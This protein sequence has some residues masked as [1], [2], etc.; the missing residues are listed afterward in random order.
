MPSAK[1]RPSRLS[2]N[3]LITK[4]KAL[5]M[6]CGTSTAHNSYTQI[7]LIYII[8]SSK[9]YTS[10][11][12]H[13]FLQSFRKLHQIIMVDCP[14]FE[15]WMCL[16]VCFFFAWLLVQIPCEHLVVWLAIKHDFLQQRIWHMAGLQYRSCLG[17][18]NY[19]RTFLNTWSYATIS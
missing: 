5:K 9:S 11:G 10:W 12:C 3:V 7:L 2:L 14:V 15:I 13:H 4:Q 6:F 18:N 8:L 16:S 1:W 19:V 17:V